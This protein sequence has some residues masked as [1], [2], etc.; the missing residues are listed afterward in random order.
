MHLSIEKGFVDFSFHLI[1]L[2]AKLDMKDSM[3]RYLHW[4]NISNYLLKTFSIEGH[5]CT[6]QPNKALLIWPYT[7]CKLVLIWIFKIKME[8]IFVINVFVGF[9]D[10]RNYRVI[11]TIFCVKKCLYLLQFWS[12]TKILEYG[13]VWELYILFKPIKIFWKFL[14]ISHSFKK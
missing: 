1:D 11:K 8:G 9:S 10:I 12:Y 5:L 3:G 4:Q 6:L 13:K 14:K 2:G 7:S